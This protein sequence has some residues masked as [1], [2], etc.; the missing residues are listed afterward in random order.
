M[1]GGAQGAKGGLYEVGGGAEKMKGRL[2]EAG[3]AA[4]QMKGGLR[5]AGGAVEKMKGGAQKVSG[6]E[7]HARVKRPD[8]AKCLGKG[9]AADKESSPP[10]TANGSRP[11][12]FTLPP[13]PMSE[14]WQPILQRNQDTCGVWGTHAPAFLVGELTLA[15]HQADGTQLAVLAQLKTDQEG[16]VDAARDARD[17]NQALIRDLCIRVPRLLEG[18]LPVGDAL[19]DNVAAVQAMPMDGVRTI[20]LR[21]QALRTLW[22]EGNARRAALVPPQGPLLA[23]AQGVAVLAAALSA[24]EGLERAVSDTRGVLSD[25]RSD[26]RLL[27]TR[28]D[29]NNKRWYVAWLGNFPAGTP[30]NDALSQIDTG[31]PGGGGNGG[32][33]SPNPPAAPVNVSVTQAA[34]GDALEGSSDPGTGV[35]MNR[36]YARLVGETGDPALAASSA[37]L[38]MAFTMAPG[39]Y[40]FT[41][42]HANADGESGPSAVVV[43]TVA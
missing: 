22:T 38:P 3:G 35:T 6:G 1:K 41:M 7:F 9:G 8:V 37:T 31:S 20:Q 17:A 16:V 23:G 39:E 28:V 25:R 13:I 4:R 36:F 2:H 10:R 33:T 27:A 42:T 15:V 5:E 14:Y 40:E 43:V 12:G 26:L 30:E 21:G 11:A 19:L 34:P 29:R 24:E 18:S 32:G